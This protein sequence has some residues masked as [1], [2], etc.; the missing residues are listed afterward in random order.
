MRMRNQLYEYPVGCGCAC[1]NSVSDDV[2]SSK[3]YPY[4]YVYYGIVLT[5][6]FH[7]KHT[8]GHMHRNIAERRRVCKI[9]ILREAKF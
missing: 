2:D 4:Y 1:A 5:M 3:H 6:S 7:N 9:C 8:A